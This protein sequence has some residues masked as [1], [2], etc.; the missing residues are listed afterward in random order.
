MQELKAKPRQ[1]A[2][3]SSDIPQPRRRAKRSS[4][5]VPKRKGGSDLF[6]VLAIAIFAAGS[7][8]IGVVMFLK[9]QGVR[10]VP[11]VAQ[12]APQGTAA[13]VVAS[14]VMRAADVQ[15]DRM[16]AQ[17]R[18]GLLARLEADEVYRRLI[19]S[20]GMWQSEMM[21]YM[22]M[23]IHE[24]GDMRLIYVNKDLP[25]L[26]LYFTGKV[27]WQPQRGGVVF[28]P[29]DV[30]EAP[31]ALPGIDDGKSDKLLKSISY[32]PL[33]KDAFVMNVSFEGR[34]MVWSVPWSVFKG[35]SAD[36]TRDGQSVPSHPVFRYIS[37]QS[38][39][40]APMSIGQGE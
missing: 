23:F 35:V 38:L 18:S 19:Q 39:R 17:E 4:A 16:D 1:S 24:K 9:Q 30:M 13:G 25:D 27:T 37:T 36:K 3:S 40:W 31:A 29:D 11:V 20:G 2:H 32:Q 26:R 10:D 8:A 22:M 12:A 14:F 6:T 15:L 34:D 7:V 5:A 28:E 33:S 21:Q